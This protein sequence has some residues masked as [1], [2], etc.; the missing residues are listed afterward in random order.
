MY[1]G[2]CYT[3]FKVFKGYMRLSIVST[4]GHKEQKTTLYIW[5]QQP[6]R[7]CHKKKFTGQHHTYEDTPHQESTTH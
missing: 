1:V 2:Y 3:L 5:T 6:E 4:I 7:P